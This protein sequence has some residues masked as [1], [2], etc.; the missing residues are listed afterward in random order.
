MVGKSNSGENFDC[1]DFP[2]L[3]T[4]P[5]VDSSYDSS[6]NKIIDQMNNDD[7]MNEMYLK[8]DL[9]IEYKAA[10][11]IVEENDLN[12]EVKKQ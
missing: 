11:K 7:K 2:N 4:G 5:E 1:N 10:P 12:P 6:V 3:L 9:L 8:Q